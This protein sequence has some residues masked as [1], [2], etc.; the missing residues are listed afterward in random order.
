MFQRLRL[1]NP[2]KGCPLALLDERIDALEDFPVG[3]LPI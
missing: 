2:F 3:A 1:A